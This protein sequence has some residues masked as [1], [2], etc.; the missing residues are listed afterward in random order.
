MDR[1]YDVI[2]FFQNIFVVRR[3]KVANFADIIE[4][5]TT[6]IKTTLKVSIK[7]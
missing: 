7:V 6:L 1:N 5:A 4:I 3:P 2:A